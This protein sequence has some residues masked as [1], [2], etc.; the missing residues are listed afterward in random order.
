MGLTLQKSKNTLHITLFFLFVFGLQSLAFAQIP[1]QQFQPFEVSFHPDN[2]RNGQ[3]FIRFNVTNQSEWQNYIRLPFSDENIRIQENQTDAPVHIGSYEGEWSLIFDLNKIDTENI[4]SL[5][6]SNETGKFINNLQVSIDLIAFSATDRNMANLSA[7]YRLNDNSLIPVPGGHIDLNTIPESEIGYTSLSLQLTLEQIYF[8]ESDEFSVILFHE[9]L[10]DDE[11]APLGIKRIEVSPGTDEGMQWMQTAGLMITE[12]MPRYTQNGVVTEYIE[13]YNPNSNPVNLKGFLLSTSD[14]KHA[15]SERVM[16]EPFSFAVLANSG[17]PENSQ[18]KAD[19]YF[20]NLS[21]PAHGS[22]VS[23]R[24]RDTEI[25]RA[26]YDANVPGTAWELSNPVNAYDG[27]AGIQQFI[28][29]ETSIDENLNG[30]PG[31]TGS[32][33]R[34]FINDIRESSWNLISVPGILNEIPQN[35]GSNLEFHNLSAGSSLQVT[36]SEIKPHTPYIIQT[37]S[38]SVR[39]FAGEQH[40][41]RIQVITNSPYSLIPN[42]NPVEINL[43][44]FR[45]PDNSPVSQSALLW[46]PVTSTFMFSDLIDHRIPAWT[47]VLIPDLDINYLNFIDGEISDNNYVE[48][49]FINMKL[50]GVNS[51]NDVITDESTMI[52][53]RGTESG[54][55]SS[56]NYPKLWPLNIFDSEMTSLIYLS[57]HNGDLNN[58]YTSG[59]YSLN[60]DHEIKIDMGLIN[61]QFEGSFTLN[62]SAMENI[63]DDWAIQ[64]IDNKTGDITDMQERNSYQ[65]QEER[66]SI[67]ESV[68]PKVPGIHALNVA[69][70]NPRFTLRIVSSDAVLNDQ[71]SVSEIPDIVELYQNYPNPFNPTTNISFYLPEPRMATVSIYNI[72]GQRV[73]ILLQDNMAAGEHTLVWDASELPSGMYIIHLEIGNRVYTRKMTLIK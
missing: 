31:L 16:V 38:N 12:I 39:L 2:Q 69:D 30:S 50:T 49:R 48:S 23:L 34:Y 25:I 4:F 45:T 72:V 73:G 43:N 44:Q 9:K 3:N 29:S 35:T 42:P 37:G 10:S 13:I 65:F 7:Y 28:P 58:L 21:L 17:L 32:T 61:Y 22:E 6:L 24:Y 26:F 55:N 20:K 18:V 1:L 19:Y 64:L 33:D 70:E 47:S 59:N 14:G 53:F 67:D 40:T 52:F 41:E 57:S 68:I 60:P 8:S 27:Y 54:A 5:S 71:N 11:T 15:I 66:T 36:L 63:P 62:W 46:N 56:G 51:S